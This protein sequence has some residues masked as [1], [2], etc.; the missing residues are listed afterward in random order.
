[1]RDFLARI[2]E[3]AWRDG[4]PL[5][6]KEIERIAGILAGGR[7]FNEQVMPWGTIT[8]AAD[9]SLFTFSPEITEWRGSPGT[10]VPFGNILTDTIEDCAANPR[11]RRF[12][13][14]VAA[15]VSACQASCPYFG[16]CGGGS[17]VNKLFEHGHLGATETAFCRLSTM[18]AADAFAV[19]AE[20]RRGEGATRARQPARE[21]GP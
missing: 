13:A 19:F 8:V 7:A 15:G 16:V 18:A 9:G 5:G 10:E 12:A 17:P 20:A 4:Y 11:F 2:L 1:M 3:L 14:G 21:A 6:I